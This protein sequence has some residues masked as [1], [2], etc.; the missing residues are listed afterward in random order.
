M[1]LDK[2]VFLREMALLAER[3]NRPELSEPLI[4][5]YYDTLNSRLDTAAFENAARIIFDGD[6]FWPSPARF[7]EAV[8]GNPKQMADDAWADMLAV[9]RKGIFPPL[10]TLPTPTRA[11]L[12]AAPLR[13]IMYA[14]SEFELNRLKR[15][16]VDAYQRATGTSDTKALPEPEPLA[17]EGFGS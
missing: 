1:S 11:A 6:T 7:I 13:E 8:Q 12:K 2:R 16:F 5:R 15:E 14:T 4:A 3:F 17:I 10:E 9:A